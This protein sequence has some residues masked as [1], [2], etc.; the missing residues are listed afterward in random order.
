MPGFNH[1]SWELLKVMWEVQHT[2]TELMARLE[3]HSNPPSVCDDGVVYRLL[4]LEMPTIVVLC[5]SGNN[6]YGSMAY[7]LTVGMRLYEY[8]QSLVARGVSHI[9]VCQVIKS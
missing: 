5:L 2:Q 4:A 9:V 1:L 3:A 6:I 7:V 8:V